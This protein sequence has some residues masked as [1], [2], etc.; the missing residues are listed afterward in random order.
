MSQARGVPSLTGCVRPTV[1]RRDWST[2]TVLG[3]VGYAVASAFAGVLASMWKLTLGERL[4]V[5]IGPPASFVFS[6][7]IATAIKRGEGIVFYRSALAAIGTVVALGLVIDG[8]VAR[9]LD[10]AVLG[11]GALLVFGRLGCLHVGCCHGRPARRGPAHV[12]AGFW[13]RWEGRTLFPIQLVESIASAVLVGAALAASRT[14]GSAA[15]VYAVGYGLVRFVLERLRGDLVRPY[16]YGLSE[17]QWSCAATLA[18]AAAWRPSGW[19]LV[20]LGALLAGA[21]ILLARRRRD[22]LFAPPHL[23]EL[24]RIC[25]A[26]LADPDHARRETGL[27]AISCHPLDDG[28]LDWV[29]SSSHAWW[30]AGAARRLGAALWGDA[31]VVEGRTP[32][33]MHVVVAR[34]E[35]TSGGEPG[36]VADRALELGVELG[37]MSGPKR[38]VER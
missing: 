4:V 8:R 10:I 23:G 6:V 15:L 17:A 13:R 28:R 30:S 2:Y 22:E 33:V 27:I 16:R 20:P 9:M 36:V 12:A 35:S 21:A 29:M 7:A 37:G 18:L 24:D 32:G 11:T 19:T 26:V 34:V 1:G 3:L 38:A 31:E 5:L 14:P 25:D